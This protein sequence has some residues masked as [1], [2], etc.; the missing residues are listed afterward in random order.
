MTNDNMCNTSTFCNNSSNLNSDSSNN[1]NN[2][3]NNTGNHK[4]NYVT[5]FFFNLIIKNTDK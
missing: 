2:N 4:Y 5:K 1:N 3:N